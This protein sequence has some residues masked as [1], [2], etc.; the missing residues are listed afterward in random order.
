VVVPLNLTV[1]GPYFKDVTFL[2]KL[3]TG[4]RAFLVTGLQV[5]VADGVVTMIVK[6]SVYA[7]PGAAQALQSMAG[8]VTPAGATQADG[9]AQPSGAAASGGT[10]S[11]P[12]GSAGGAGTAPS[13]APSGAP[14]SSGAQT[15]SPAASAP[16]ASVSAR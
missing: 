4:T 13:S 10:G 11:S 12:M 7:L 5:S 6:G 15:T 9:P 16:G 3:Q 8:G 14:T 1:H 2:K